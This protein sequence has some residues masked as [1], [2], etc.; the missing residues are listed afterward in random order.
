MAAI[1]NDT[2]NRLRWSRKGHLL[3]LDIAKGLVYLHNNQV[4]LRLHKYLHCIFE[5]SFG[6]SFWQVLLP[7]RHTLHSSFAYSMCIFH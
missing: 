5:L 6:Q 2:Q 1:A 3:T 7:R 4:W